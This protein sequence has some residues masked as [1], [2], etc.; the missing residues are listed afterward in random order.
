MTSGMATNP[1]IVLEEFIHASMQLNSSWGGPWLAPA[2]WSLND[3]CNTASYA[4][5]E[6]TTEAVT[7]LCCLAGAKRW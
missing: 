5:F 4:K 6:T 3:S 1:N 7:C 2:C